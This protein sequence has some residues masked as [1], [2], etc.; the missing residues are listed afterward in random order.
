MARRGRELAIS[1]SGAREVMARVAPQ[2]I[3]FSIDWLPDGS[4]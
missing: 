1:T 2:T 3:P 4:S